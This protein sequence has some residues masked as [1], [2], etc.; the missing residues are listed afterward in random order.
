M[1]PASATTEN[2]SS[3]APGAP[4]DTRVLPHPKRGFIKLE[5]TVAVTANGYE[6]FGDAGRGSNRGGAQKT[7]PSLAQ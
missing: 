3:F 4:F 6:A 5:D 1:N 7:T 2:P